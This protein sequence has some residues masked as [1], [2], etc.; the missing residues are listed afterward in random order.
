MLDLP[1]FTSITLYTDAWKSVNTVWVSD[2]PL[3][4]MFYYDDGALQSVETVYYRGSK[5]M[6]SIFIVD[7]SVAFVNSILLCNNVTNLVPY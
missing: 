6:N 3:V 5:L 2:I 7:V 4:D 1:S